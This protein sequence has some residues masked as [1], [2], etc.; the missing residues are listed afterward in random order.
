MQIILVQGRFRIKHRIFHEKKELKKLLSWIKPSKTSKKS[1]EL[2]FRVLQSTRNAGHVCAPPHTV[3]VASA[4][5]VY[6]ARNTIFRIEIF[7]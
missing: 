3:R 1:A 2:K 7:G 4:H 6:A 5:N